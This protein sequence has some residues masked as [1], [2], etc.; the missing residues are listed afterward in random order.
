MRISRFTSPSFEPTDNR[1]GRRL[2]LSVQGFALSW[3]GYSVVAALGLAIVLALTLN[4]AAGASS[5]N[6][7]LAGFAL[8]LLVCAVI[9]LA[10]AS[11]KISATRK[12]NGV[13]EQR[14]VAEARASR[15]LDAIRLLAGPES[16]SDS[17]GDA[18][19]VDA[20]LAAAARMA[21]GYTTAAVFKLIDAHGVFVPS[22]WSNWRPAGELATSGQSGEEFEPVDGHTPGARAARQGSAVVLSSTETSGNG[23]PGWAERAGFTQ[24]IVT[25]IMQSLNTIGIVYVFNKSSTPPT[26]N[27][28]EQL[29]LVVGFGSNF[30]GISRTVRSKLSC[31]STSVVS[32]GPSS[33]PFRVPDGQPWRRNSGLTDVNM[34]NFRLD[35]ELERLELDGI[36]I[37]ISPTEFLLLHTLSSSPGVPVSSAELVNACWA[38]N[39]KP[40]DNAIDVAIFR[41]RRKLRV[42]AL[43]KGLIKTVRGSGYMLV[44]PVTD[45]PG[46]A[47]LSAVSAVPQTAD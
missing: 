1:Y 3:G 2:G 10:V 30:Y 23:L 31:R 7:P 41:L 29:E 45:H 22:T 27:E 15:V 26:I 16:Q 34:P 38:A 40:A 35:A 39:A 8:A 12:E 17:T 13:L 11:S 32:G 21:T 9:G 43:G 37:S 14:L 28:I 4:N 6:W 5:A 18:S 33:Q 46:P 47:R 42:T 25:P 19:G 44:I 20:R 36:S 24:G